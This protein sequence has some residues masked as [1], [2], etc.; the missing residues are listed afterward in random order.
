[1]KGRS[2]VSESSV[3]SKFK[4]WTK[5][6]ESVA[7]FDEMVETLAVVVLQAIKERNQ[8]LV[9]ETGIILLTWIEYLIPS[10]RPNFFYE[11]MC[12]APKPVN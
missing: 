11:E 2:S 7:A 4:I 6:G 9:K 5:Q 3:P 10:D 8:K 1:V 12:L